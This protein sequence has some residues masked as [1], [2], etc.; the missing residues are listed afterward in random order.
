MKDGTID[1]LK[2]KVMEWK[3]NKTR[4][5]RA[6]LQSLD[7]VV[8][9]GCKWK[10]VGMHQLVEASDVRKHYL[11]ACLAVHPDKLRG[12]ENEELAKLI[13]VELNDAWSEF[14]KQTRL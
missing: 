14:E 6:L 1:P 11:R 9:E 8:W 5:I 10:P 12:D 13:F 2:L 7:T 4:N 3:E